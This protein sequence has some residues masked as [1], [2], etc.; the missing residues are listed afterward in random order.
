MTHWIDRLTNRENPFE[1]LM[2]EISRSAAEPID[3]DHYCEL[4]LE[5][6]AQIFQPHGAGLFLKQKA[7]GR[8]HLSARLGLAIDDLQL[9][10]NHP[11]PAF[12]NRQAKLLHGSDL[13]ILPLFRALW[14]EER[15]ALGQLNAE[16]FI[17][18]KAG[19]DLVG[20]LALGGKKNGRRYR[21]EDE[22]QL[23][24]LCNQ[25]ALAIRLK[26]LAT[27]E[28]RWR[29]EAESMQRALS[30]ITTDSD[31][32]EALHRNLLHIRDAFVYDHASISLIQ[33]DRLVVTAVH[34]YNHP[35]ELLGQDDPIT[36]NEPFQAIQSSRETLLVE[37]TSL[38]A[39]FKHF[40]GPA[41]LQAWMGVPLISRG[42]VIGLLALSS[43]KAGSFQV[44]PA[45]LE[46]VQ[47]HAN[48]AAIIV[49]KA[50]LF[51][52][53]RQRHQ[54]ADALQNIS[55]EVENIQN[56]EQGLD[57]LLERIGKA[58]PADITM[59]FLAEGGQLNLARTVVSEALN[60]EL[61]QAVLQPA[62]EA[63]AFANLHYLVN[64]KRAQVISDTEKDPDWVIGPVAIRSWAGTPVVADGKVIACFTFASLKPTAYQAGL[65][66][67]LGVFANQAAMALQNFRLFKEVRELAIH[68]ERTGLFNHRHFLD[69]GEREFRR[70][71]RFHHHLSVILL[72]VDHFSKVIDNYGEDAS[73]QVL[74]SVADLINANIRNV[75]VPCR[76][77]G[78]IFSVIL[79]ETDQLGAE[80]IS[81]R[82]RGLIAESPNIT[83]AGLIKVTVSIGVAVM[84]TDSLD[85]SALLNNVTLSLDEARHAGRNRVVI[86][87]AKS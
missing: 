10:L 16:L 9:D 19:G 64:D 84:E 12:F 65:A 39:R 57:F 56:F 7:A 51:Q 58:V 30:E 87:P 49:E 2:Q 79:T 21:H 27:A 55:S 71:R 76:F 50:R 54:M 42:E 47:A 83:T 69:L 77:Q 37:E 28:Q 63:S 5:Q 48:Q 26:Y 1:A 13:D 8:F 17:P 18:L 29:Q 85:L 14:E 73:N 25:A 23:I 33:D 62:Y 4:V 31:L 66:E 60:P 40:A 80:I 6:I 68:D 38:D 72:E 61:G 53:E 78:E 67:L 36:A 41:V 82:L 70:A 11:L 74:R 59:L 24:L 35:A 22:Q 32:G 3:L 43:R 81:E 75:D 44:N 45:R 20:I 86:Y 15:Q 46:L 34:G 52:M